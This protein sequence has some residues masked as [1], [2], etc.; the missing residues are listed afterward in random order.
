MARTE[1]ASSR[2]PSPPAERATFKLATRSAVSRSVSWLIWST[3]P[4]ILGLAAAASVELCR[5]AMRCWSAGAETARTDVLLAVAR[6]WRAQHWAA[7]LHERDILWV[8]GGGR[9]GG[10]AGAGSFAEVVVVVVVEDAVWSFF[11]SPKSLQFGDRLLRDWLVLGDGLTAG[12]SWGY[13]WN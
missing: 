11:Q 7:Y 9:P 6:S 2:H 13:G 8:G 4:E 5:R 12:A 1:T 3:I 10:G